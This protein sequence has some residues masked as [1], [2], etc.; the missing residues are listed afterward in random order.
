[1][2]AGRYDFIIEQGA[3]FRKVFRWQ[4][5]NGDPVDL[6]G[7]TAK[8]QAWDD[9][10]RN[11]LI[12]FNTQGTITIDAEAGSV[13]VE[14]QDDVTSDLDFRNARSSPGPPV[15]VPNALGSSALLDVRRETT[16][17][18]LPMERS[19][20][21]FWCCPGPPTARDGPGNPLRSMGREPAGASG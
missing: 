14:L 1:M 12:D 6:T 21:F 10:H 7:T 4:Q 9:D 19:R 16:L 3:T 17:P 20:E 18:S 11:K 2:T 15:L 5:S 13:T 8:M